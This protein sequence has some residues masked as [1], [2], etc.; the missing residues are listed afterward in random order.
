M[1]SL[2]YE[3]MTY[4]LSPLSFRSAFTCTTF[5]QRLI[6]SGAEAE[7]STQNAWCLRAQPRAT[8]AELRL[9]QLWK[10][11]QMF[12]RSLWQL[13]AS[14]LICAIWATWG[15]RLGTVNQGQNN[16][17]G[18]RKPKP[19]R[20]FAWLPLTIIFDLLRR[21]YGWACPCDVLSFS[22]SNPVQPL[23]IRAFGSKK[24]MT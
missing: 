16:Q 13:K 5:E 24:G 17:Q 7:N 11:T 18:A 1:Y 23:R 19:R 6:D 4:D 10:W 15:R 2:I 9:L 8:A 14:I 20:L 3:F 12:R 21:R 22:N